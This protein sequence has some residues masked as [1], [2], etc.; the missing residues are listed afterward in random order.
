MSP[1]GEWMQTLTTPGQA[2][3]ALSRQELSKLSNGPGPGAHVPGESSAAAGQPA[4]ST[5]PRRML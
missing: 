2:L 3:H 5:L 4:P 1:E